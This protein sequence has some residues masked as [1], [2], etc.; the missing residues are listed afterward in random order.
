MD[1]AL[2]R[3]KTTKWLG[4]YKYLLLIVLVGVGLMLIP[5]GKG[6]EETNIPIATTIMP[7]QDVN[8]QLEEILTQIKGAGKVKVML[9]LRAGQQTVYQTDTPSSDRVD[10]VII[11]GQDRTQS[12]LVQQI[13]AP[14]YRGAIVLC[15]GADSPSVCLAIKDAVAKVTGLDAS[16]ISVLKMK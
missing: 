7:Q 1:I 15:Q 12:G 2:I 8:A 9:T 13:L 14:T 5:F 10:T 16:E 6:E 3:E 4:K 11:T